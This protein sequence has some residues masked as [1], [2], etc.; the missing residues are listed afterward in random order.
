MTT[1]APP[2]WPDAWMPPQGERL[3]SNWHPR[4]EGYMRVELDQFRSPFEEPIVVRHI[5]GSWGAFM[6]VLGARQGHP[7]SNGRYTLERFH[8]WEPWPGLDGRQYP[9]HLACILAVE[10]ELANKEL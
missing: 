7:L 4:A 6:R 2:L 5:F 1:P 8:N 3:P 9:T 10:F